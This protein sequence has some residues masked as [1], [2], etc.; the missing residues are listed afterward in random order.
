MRAHLPDGH[1]SAPS[2][3]TGMR[4]HVVMLSLWGLVNVVSTTFGLGGVG[5]PVYPTSY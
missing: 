1:S 3:V 4:P 5:A 2:A